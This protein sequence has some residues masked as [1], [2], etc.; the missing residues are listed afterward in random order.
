MTRRAVW[1]VLGLVLTA[2]FAAGQTTSRITEVRVYRGEALVTREVS[3]A[4]KPG[5]Q[6]V[7]V[8]GLPEEV[9]PESLYAA[10]D[11]RLTIRAVRFRAS[12]TQDAPRPEVRALDQQIA[13]VQDTLTRIQADTQ[14]IEQQTQY[15]TKLE[16]F[17][18]PTA[19]MEMTK[20]VL[21]AQRITTIT[22][23]VFTQRRD[24]GGRRLTL[25]K[26]QKAASQKLEVL[27]RQRAELADVAPKAVREAVVTLEAAQAGPATLALSYLVGGVS[28]E[29]AYVAR[30]N[31]TRDKLALEYHGVVTQTSGEDWPS[32]Q[33][34]LSTGFPKM[35][36][37]SPLLSPLRLA[38]RR[39]QT[40]LATGE[41]L[42]DAAAYNTR[43]RELEQQ[44]KAAPGPPMRPSRDGKD[45]AANK[46][47]QQAQ[48]AGGAFAMPQGEVADEQMVSANFLAGRLQNMEM[49][50][51]DE[52]VRAARKLSKAAGGLAVDYTIAGK[53]SLQSR[54]DQQ[55]FRIA[56]LNLPA[57]C[58]YTAV[59]LLSDFVYQAAETVNTTDTPLLPGPYNAYL[60]GMFAGRGDLPLVARGETMTVGFG[61]ETQL[62]VARDLADKQTETKGGN[63]V[64]TFNYHLRLQNFMGKPAKVRV[65]DRI[66]LAPSDQVSV[67]LV[68]T[69]QALSTDPVYLELERPRGLLRWDV[70]V[71]ATATGAKAVSFPYQLKMEFDKQLT[72]ADMAEDAQA[73]MR[74][75]LESLRELKR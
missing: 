32:V 14:I 65:W 29:P 16:T 49:A 17:V 1:A 70:D 43:R 35:I 19:Q 9:V 55:I 8:P 68:T 38:L 27:Q 24:L 48:T 39:S 63:K 53:V 73:S 45:G 54:T 74:K 67:S 20:G 47:G 28:W 75:D 44:A 60:D 69:Q 72:I 31:G 64:Q 51:S 4:A 18:A 5:S 25:I 23:F 41:P 15:L 30:L 58:Y 52:V 22:E 11:E 10:G 21:D 61:T 3:F 7:V 12:A 2:G 26:E 66:P 56:L 46:P 42:G 34:V 71:P 33:L 57:N 62:R 36:A 50:A 37:S 59:P 40:P 13:D 6:E